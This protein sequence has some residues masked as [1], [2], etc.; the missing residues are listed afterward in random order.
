MLRAWREWTATAPDEIISVAHL[1]RL[2]P[3]PQLPEPLRGRSFVVVEAA[4]LGDAGPGAEL[5]QPLRRLGPELDTF[6]TTPPSALGQLNMDPDQPIPFPG[7]AAF[8][9][10]FPTAAVDALAG[11]AGPDTGTLLASSEVCHLGGAL[12]RPVPDGG[13]Q[14]SIDANY[15]LIAAGIAPH[16]TWPRPCARPRLARCSRAPPTA[17]CRRSRPPTTP[18]R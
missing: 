16:P 6:A 15:L 5:I 9:S 7:N 11:L 10:D 12:A 2:P 8:L 1:V 18:A 13:A 4:Y 17:A 14:P 3:L